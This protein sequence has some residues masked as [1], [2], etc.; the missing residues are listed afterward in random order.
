MKQATTFSIST[1]TITA[2]RLQSSATNRRRWDGNYRLG[3]Y[4]S[5]GGF[6]D[7]PIF[8]IDVL[9]SSTIGFFPN[10]PGPGTSQT[11]RSPAHN[12][13]D[14][15]DTR[16]Y[17]FSRKSTGGQK[18]HPKAVYASSILLRGHTSY[19]DSLLFP[20]GFKQPQVVDINSDD[21][22]DFVSFS[23]ENYDYDSDSDL[24]SESSFEDIIPSPS[25]DPVS[26]HELNALPG[27]TKS[28]IQVITSYQ[29]NG[30]PDDS[31]HS[32]PSQTQPIERIWLALVVYL[33]TRE[34]SFLPLTSLGGR[35]ATRKSSFA[36]CSP[37]SMYRLAD[38]LGLEELQKLSLDAI[39]ANLSNQ[40]IMQEVFCRFTSL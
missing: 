27:L 34:V 11:S 6:V 1:S 16:F 2:L 23:D 36:A 26:H 30:D 13:V 31:A 8:I 25:I 38:K 7:S 40:N 21:T 15:I 22:Q 5:S 3:S 12:G 28:L 29:M 4:F 37:K 10:P 20:S 32:F 39:H 33:Y 35:T 14:L 24:D 17:L 19:I 18:T 9:F